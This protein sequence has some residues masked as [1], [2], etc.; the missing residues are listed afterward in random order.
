MRAFDRDAV[1]RASPIDQVIA[2]LLNQQPQRVAGG[3]LGFLCPWHEDKRPT[4]H[5]NPSKDGGVYM[6]RACG[7]AKG[8][9]FSFVQRYQGV[10]FVE[11]LAWL[12][13]R[14]G[15]SSATT[16]Q[17]APDR[18]LV[19]EFIYTD[20]DGA[21]THRVRRYDLPTTDPTTG[22]PEK[23]FPVSHWKNSAW[24]NGKG[25]E[26]MPLYNL[27]GIQ[28]Q[29]TVYVVE[30]EA[31][32]EALISHGWPATTTP[33]GARNCRPE[34]ADQ[35]KA[36]GVANVVM[37]PDADPAGDEHDQKFARL[38]TAVGLHQL[39]IVAIPNLPPKGDV[40]DYFKAGGTLADLAVL[41][42]AAKLYTPPSLDE[43][44]QGTD[45]TPTV[46]HVNGSESP[47][48]LASEWPAPL[49]AS[50]FCG[51]CGD[52]ARAIEPHTEADPAALLVQQLVAFGNIIGRA[53]YFR[54]E[55]DA[56]YLNLF[57]VMV[58]V[59]AKGRKG[60]SFGQVK[61]CYEAIEPVWSGH[62]QKS[63]LSSG[64]GLIWAV[65]DPIL[66]SQPQKV[67]GRPT[68]NTETVTE[69]PGVEDK[70]LLVFEG[71]LARALRVL[72]REGNTLS[73]LMRQAWDGHDLRV[74][75]KNSPAKATG[76]HIS[77]I[78]HI[79]ADELRR[80]LDATEAA[81]G[82]GN[83]FLWVCVKRSK[84]LPDGGGVPHLEPL[85]DRL[86][87]AVEHAKTVGEMRRDT[88]AR[89]LWHAVYEQLST[90]LPGML[91][92][93]TG[94]AEAQVMRL[95]CLYA[96]GELSS[97]VR[98]HH[99]EAA[100]ELWGTASSPLGTSSATVWA[101]RRRTKSCGRSRTPARTDCRRRTS[102]ACSGTTSRPARSGGR[103]RCSRNAASPGGRSI[104][105]R[106]DER[107]SV[108]CIRHRAIRITNLTKEA[109]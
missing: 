6:C 7:N 102:S 11:S 27:R 69:D 25:S 8:D 90:G 99:L 63:G 86:R 32:A 33:G 76:A 85:K 9:V 18:K 104:P 59:S 3:E 92:A 20:K 15:I 108:G 54:A 93:M 24:V 31:C 50:A 35:L 1:K 75:T 72:A 5:V 28:G 48:P 56:H 57:S 53:P 83:R 65:R 88:E 97:E 52:I 58:G 73:A 14:A 38:C 39:K 100:L 51:V 21:P 12:A 49:R 62:C 66:K 68:G 95:A 55:A 70:R 82:F 36:A 109:P 96:L 4:L 106:A 10:S 44:R 61:N 22:K 29:Q 19:A 60:V 17:N 16:T 91:G 67:G 47:T 103:S 26:S 77:V 46:V 94:R 23:E 89:K 45:A 30:G 80:Y 37:L 107:R 105:R 13:Q 81:N 34:H 84:L 78:G 42:R 40:I 41:V 43:L 98:R 101:T 74:L 87:A 2:E 64:E 79:T 71:E